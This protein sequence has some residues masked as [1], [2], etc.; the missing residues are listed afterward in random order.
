DEVGRALGNDLS[1]L[2]GRGVL[3][4][5]RGCQIGIRRLER[6]GERRAVQCR[7]GLAEILVSLGDLPEEEVAVG[8][9]AGDGVGAQRVHAAGPVLDHFGKGVLAGRPLVDRQPP[10]GRIDLVQA[11]RDVLAAHQRNASRG[12]GD[13]GCRG[14]GL[15]AAARRSAWP[16]SS[17]AASDAPGG[18]VWICSLLWASPWGRSASWSARRGRRS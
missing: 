10:P 4:S 2:A 16:L 15:A 9:D 14:T 11:V 1:R 3:R 8:A 5:L 17:G 12:S 13:C 18:W 6:G 7:A